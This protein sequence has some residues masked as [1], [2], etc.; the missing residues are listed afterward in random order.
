[1]KSLQNVDTELMNQIESFLK[2][3]KKA[4][5]PFMYG[6]G[7]YYDQLKL[8][9][10]EEDSELSS[11]SNSPIFF[12]ESPELR[13]EDMCYFSHFSLDDSPSTRSSKTKPYKPSN[14]SIR[15]DSVDD[16]ITGSPKFPS[17]KTSVFNESSRPPPMGSSCKSPQTFTI[18]TVRGRLNHPPLKSR[19]SLLSVSPVEVS[20]QSPWKIPS[21][22]N[23]GKGRF[24]FENDEWP[25]SPS[26]SPSSNKNSTTPF[27]KTQKLS[28]KQ[29][30][31][32]KLLS[33]TPK[34]IQPLPW[35]SPIP[36]P[37]PVS[38]LD[39]QKEQS[40]RS[41]LNVGK[42]DWASPTSSKVSFLSIQLEQERSSKLLKPKS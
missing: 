40:T 5:M 14:D 39:L 36:S 8:K 29:R 1:M 16:P 37:R 22:P 19:Y 20:P 13:P 35:K 10:L 24:S 23:H 6:D 11:D 3:E 9:R 2:L 17:S 4:T 25:L 12:M 34:A 26:Y 31:Q 21:S 32:Q 30:K 41:S 38:I 42:N 15:L 33:E 18:P 27:T 7:G 28:Q